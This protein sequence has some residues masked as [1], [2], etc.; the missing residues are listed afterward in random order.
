MLCRTV[1]LSQFAAFIGLSFL[2]DNLKVNKLIRHNALQSVYL[3]VALFP[4]S[5]IIVSAYTIA[6]T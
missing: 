2:G 6:N 1:P 5:L 4:A 3:D